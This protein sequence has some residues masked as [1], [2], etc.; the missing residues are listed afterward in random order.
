MTFLAE[1]GTS[2]VHRMNPWTKG[3][4]LGIVILMAV[5]MNDAVLLAVLFASVLVF[6]ALARLPFRLLV[7]WFTLPVLF[8]V[9]I[10]VLFIFTEPGDPLA[11]LDLFG[12]TI[13]ITDAGVML[14]VTLLLRALAVVAYSLTL[15]MT[16]KYSHMS[17]LVS[18]VQIGRAHV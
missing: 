8:V 16:T 17:Y 18:K 4:L 12:R 13:S 6:Y 2:P 15:F 14:L 10:A 5:V 9:T 3:A 1:Y 7:G 11:S